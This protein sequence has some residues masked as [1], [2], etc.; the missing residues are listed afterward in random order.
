VTQ[1]K[2]NISLSPPR[3]LRRF[4]PRALVALLCAPRRPLHILK[5]AAVSPPTA[6]VE[7]RTSQKVVL[8][9]ED[10]F[11]ACAA[12][13]VVFVGVAHGWIGLVGRLEG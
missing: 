2:T 9:A 12:G 10:D 4:Q 5:V 13:F 7:S 3:S 6:R 11:A 1:S 8:D